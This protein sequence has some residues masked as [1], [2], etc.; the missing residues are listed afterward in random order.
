VVSAD[1]VHTVFYIWLVAV[2]PIGV[3]AFVLTSISQAR[4]KRRVDRAK[5]EAIEA[6]RGGADIS[7]VAQLLVDRHLPPIPAIRTTA[8]VTGSSISQ[9]RSA[10]I[11]CLP[12]KRQRALER[13]GPRVDNMVA[14]WTGN[15]VAW[16]TDIF[17]Q[18]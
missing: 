13:L 10:V 9:A 4:L 5:Y 11:S 7:Q 15:P 6:A 3:I 14:R 17:H 16:V 2:L 1:I 8:D 18:S 12:E